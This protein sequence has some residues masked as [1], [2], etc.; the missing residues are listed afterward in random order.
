VSPGMKDLK[1]PE[2]AKGLQIQHLRNGRECYLI[3]STSLACNSKNLV[4]NN[5]WYF[6]IYK[7]K[8]KKWF[9]KFTIENFVSQHLF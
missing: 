7:K 9:D 3:Q 8:K 2:K 5:A 6:H 4:L 1:K